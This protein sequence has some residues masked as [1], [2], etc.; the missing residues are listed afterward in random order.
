LFD[1]IIIPK[2]EDENLKEDGGGDTPLLDGLEN[3]DED[4]F[5]NL[6]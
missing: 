4:P 3:T 1:S 2:N 6:P 5:N